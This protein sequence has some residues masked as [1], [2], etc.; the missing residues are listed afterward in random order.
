MDIDF[1]NVAL[2]LLDAA[3]REGYLHLTFA[4]LRSSLQGDPADFTWLTVGATYHTI[5]V[6]LAVARYHAQRHYAEII[7]LA[8]ALPARNRGIGTAL[9]LDIEKRLT[10]LGVSAFRL[11]YLAGHAT[12]PALERV[13]QKCDWPLPIV[14]MYLYRMGK[15]AQHLTWLDWP[16]KPPPDLVLFDWVSL[17]PAEKE[18]IRHDPSLKYA[19]SVSPFLDEAQI[20]P[21]NSL[22]LRYRGQIAGW[23]ITH[24]LSPTT[25]RYSSVFVR[26]DLRDLGGMG[27]GVYLMGESIKRH[28]PHDEI[29]NAF[30]FVE[31]HNT[32]MLR[33]IQ[34]YAVPY[35]TAVIERRATLKIAGAP[36][37]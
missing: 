6:A 28:L 27:V 33:M 32:P 12:T 5:P 30:F 24:R 17:T 35:A 31:A 15:T 18:Q 23:I 34:K 36:Q 14:D 13:L 29:P 3:Q 20:E 2:H 19:R 37:R 9:L 22:G 26:E 16:F 1:N 11:T 10:G 25:L 8:V 4:G 7:S 21:L